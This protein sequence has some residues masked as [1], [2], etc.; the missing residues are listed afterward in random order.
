[1]SSKRRQHEIYFDGNQIDQ[2]RAIEA[3]ADLFR[4]QPRE[5]VGRVLDGPGPLAGA[6]CTHEAPANCLKGLGITSLAAHR[7]P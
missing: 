6:E 2:L 3:V 5:T 4:G 1:M 7:V